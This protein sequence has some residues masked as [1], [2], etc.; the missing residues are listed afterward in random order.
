MA[1]QGASGYTDIDFVGD[2]VCPQAPYYQAWEAAYLAW[3]KVSLRAFD[4]VLRHV[5]SLQWLNSRMFRRMSSANVLDVLDQIAPT[6]TATPVVDA[7]A[8]DA[9]RDATLAQSMQEAKSQ[10]VLLNATE[11]RRRAE[12]Q[13][14]FTSGGG[15][16]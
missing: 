16:I 11:V 12:Y 7:V 9:S 15:G 14:Q 8:A 13:Q 5:D 4:A 10:A 3:S 1:K 6:T 2:A